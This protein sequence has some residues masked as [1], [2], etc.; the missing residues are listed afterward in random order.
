[1]SPS[2]MKKDLKSTVLKL[3]IVLYLIIKTICNDTVIGVCS[4]NGKS[5]SLSMIPVCCRSARCKVLQ[6]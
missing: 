4:A 6:S 1:M 3:I 5:S 2:N